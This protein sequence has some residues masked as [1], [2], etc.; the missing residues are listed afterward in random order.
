MQQEKLD[1]GQEHTINANPGDSLYLWES[2]G[3]KH[4]LTIKAS[5]HNN[6]LTVF[7]ITCDQLANLYLEIGRVLGKPPEPTLHHLRQI[8]EA[9]GKPRPSQ[10]NLKI[11][12]VILWTMETHDG[13]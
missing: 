3:E 8:H 12:L 9:V 6:V 4:N 13:G 7:G 10:E 11:L 5:T 1:R 2:F